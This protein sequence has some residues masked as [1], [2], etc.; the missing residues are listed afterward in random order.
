MPMRTL[1]LIALLCLAGCSSAGEESSTTRPTEAAHPAD[2]AR[3]MATVA[4]TPLPALSI[5]AF[6]GA[7]GVLDSIRV[8]R[9]ERWVQ[10]L[11]GQTDEPAQST[12]TD[13]DTVDINLDGFTDI[14]QQVMWSAGANVG[15]YFWLYDQDSARFVAAPEYGQKI[16]RY[17]L[18]RA[19]REIVVRST[20][21]HA[22]AIFEED[23]YQPKG[24][25][26]LRIR[27]THQDWNDEQERY[28][29]TTGRLEG[30]QWVEKADTFTAET[31][32]A[33]DG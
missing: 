21:G 29:R 1:P 11:P 7:E 25:S 12:E 32:P 24:R 8:F 17:D 33:P 30:G 20:G 26:L 19:K 6:H 22:G 10:T 18:D 13:V 9:G 23:V 4:P 31:L 28:V 2:T 15:Y 5:R 27:A 16:Q 3:L 14:Q